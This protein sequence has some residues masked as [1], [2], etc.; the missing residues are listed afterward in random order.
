MKKT[1]AAFL[2]IFGLLVFPLSGCDL[3]EE[4]QPYDVIVE[5]LDYQ[6]EPLEEMEVTTEP[7]EVSG[8]TDEDGKVTLP[9][10]EG[11]VDIQVIDEDEY[12]IFEPKTVTEEN[13]GETITF[14]PVETRG[15]LQG[16]LSIEGGP[17]EDKVSVVGIF[18]GE[19]PFGIEFDW[20]EGEETIP[21]ELIFVLEESFSEGE[22]YI[23]FA[24]AG[25]ENGDPYIGYFG[26]EDPEED[27]ATPV[28]IEPLT[29]KEDKDFQLFPLDEFDFDVDALEE[30][31]EIG[32]MEIISTE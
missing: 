10:I 30:K 6:E 4:E 7:H 29:S 32:E 31:F 23:L 18:I 24:Q 16:T 19:M 21:Y 3:V 17:E 25:E 9:D 11:E 27:Q 15:A 28:E 14:E 22:E 12:S 2:L 5:V 26:V 8:T 13:A 20:P 1:Y